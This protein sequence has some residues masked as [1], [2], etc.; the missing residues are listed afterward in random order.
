[1][2]SSAT[3]S[4][5]SLNA[6]TVASDSDAQ[7]R[8]RP[9]I[10]MVLRA[11]HSIGTGHLMRLRS[12]IPYLKQQ[13]TVRLY[14]YAFA[15]QLRPLCSDYDE[16]FTFETKEDILKHLLALPLAP[17]CAQQGEAIAA[18]ATEYLPQ[19]LVIDDYA[20]DK[21]FEAQLYPRCKIFVV[22]DL[23][24]RP[25][26]CH[27]LL[28]QTLNT[29]EAEYRALCN[30]ECQLLLGSQY[31]LTLECFY[32][33]QRQ[34]NYQ[35]NCQCAAHHLPLCE[36]VQQALQEPVQTATQTESSAAPAPEATSPVATAEATKA[37]SQSLPRVFVNFGGA[38]PV[39]AC[40]K[41]TQSIVAAHMY[42]RYAFTLLAGAANPDY[43]ALQSL[44]Q[45]IPA[46]WQANFTL[47]RHCTDVADLF[48]RHDIALGAYGG[49]FRERIAAGLP[50]VGVIIADNQKGADEIVDHYQL[51]LNLK[52]EQLSDPQAVEHAL[53]QL[54]QHRAQYTQN[55]LKV[56]DG[57]GLK[58]IVKAIFSLLN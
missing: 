48:M 2:L 3:T 23:F 24:D 5:S 37:N 33:Q 9:C 11:N 25:H 38:D 1:M 21:S 40:L 39:S 8:Y 44:V 55:C 41:V 22:D 28:D 15:E 43:E 6:K 50:T 45:A 17:D 35:S 49:M 18:Q 34:L 27:M 29:H 7:S 12:L 52:L 20:I 16:V 36:R 19:V 42:E 53:S 32:P 31:S 30:P 4:P 26:Q 58:R 10:A 14:V 46:E 56:Y 57:Q 47:I 51:G 13:A 54:Y